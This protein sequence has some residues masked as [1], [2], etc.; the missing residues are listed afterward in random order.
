MGV[1]IYIGEQAKIQVYLSLIFFRSILQYYA[2]VKLLHYFFPFAILLCGL[3]S[4]V[5]AI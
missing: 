4:M 2:L 3:C 5:V 1:A